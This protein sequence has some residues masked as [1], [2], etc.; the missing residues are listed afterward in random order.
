[1]T[2]MWRNDVASTSFRRHVPTRFLINQCHII[3]FLIL[4]SDKTENSRIEL[5]RIFLQAPS[6]Q[7]KVTFIIILPFNLVHFLFFPVSHRNWRK[8]WVD[9]WGGGKGYVAPPLQLFG[10]PGSPS[11]LPTPVDYYYLPPRLRSNQIQIWLEDIQQ[12]QRSHRHQSRLQ[13]RLQHKPELLRHKFHR[14]RQQQRTKRWDLLHH[15]RR[16]RLQH[17]NPTRRS[18]RRTLK[19]CQKDVTSLASNQRRSLC[20]CT[21]WK[22]LDSNPQTSS[23]R[24]YRFEEEEKRNDVWQWYPITGNTFS[25]RAR[26]QAT[27]DPPERYQQPVGQC[28]Q[29]GRHSTRL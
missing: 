22:G 19:A 28:A 9:Y 10:G 5:K 14:R 2:S 16:R 1:M 15:H 17:R 8:M 23:G 21:G 29:A 7:I 3:T 4:K 12:S 6:N 25:S 18:C 11:P 24:L 27:Q 26:Q 20:P 13:R